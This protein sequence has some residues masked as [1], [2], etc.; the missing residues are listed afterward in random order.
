MSKEKIRTKET[1]VLV[2]AAQ[3]DFLTGR[4][5]LIAELWDA[6]IKAEM[7]YKKNPKLLNQL[8]YCEETGIP[9]VAII[10]QQ[11]MDDGVVK[12]RDVAT[13]KEIDVPK[14]NLIEEIKKRLE[15]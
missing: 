4:M 13:R 14:E 1:Q 10:G 2:A 15:K 3:K 8:Q 9:L 12:L 6:G 11:E 5:K 7:L